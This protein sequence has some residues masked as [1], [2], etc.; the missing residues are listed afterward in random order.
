MPLYTVTTQVGAL[1]SEDKSTLAGELTAFHSEYAGVSKN[2]VHIVF[3]EYAPGNG[4]TAG[5]VAAAAA[6]TLLIRSGRSAEYKR[7]LLKRL[8]QLL[9]DATGAADD[10]IVIGIQEVPASQAMEMGQIMPDVAEQ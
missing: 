4:F 5:E 10:Q 6:L 9:Q 8:W 3:Q 7:G 2:W 1:S